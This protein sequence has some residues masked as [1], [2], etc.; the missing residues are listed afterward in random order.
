MLQYSM[1]RSV[2]R[3]F[4]SA[5]LLSVVFLLLQSLP[6]VLAQRAGDGGHIF[7][8][9]LLNPTDGYSYLAKMRQGFEGAWSFTLPY[10]AQ[11]GQ[12]AAI[13]LYYLLLGHVAR[14]L[15]WSLVFTFHGA[16]LLGAAA[17]C[18][19]LYR[20]FNAIVPGLRTWALAIALFGSGF[21]WL[22]VASGAFT[23][24]FWVAEMYPFLAS[25]ANAHFPLG[26]ALQIFLIT[27]TDPPRPLAWLLA[28][29]VGAV[30]YP[31]GWAV[32]AA[33]LCAAALLAA[34]RKQESAAQWKQA[35]WVVAGGLPYALYALV[36][37]NTHPALAGWNVQN[38][39]PAMPLWDLVTS[40][41]P[42]LLLALPSVYFALT[43]RQ[44]AV[45]L[46][47]IWLLVCLVFLYLPFGLQRRMSSG[48]YIPVIGLAVFAIQHWLHAAARRRL[49]LVLLFLLVLPTNLLILL[50]GMQASRE[51]EAALFLRADEVAAY[52][53]LT[54]HSAPGALL[55]APERNS[56]HAPA[57]VDVRVW[58]AHP[59]ETVQAEQ[60]KGEQ[61]AFFA[62]DLPRETFLAAHA[63]DYI[64]WDVSTA[65]DTTL[66]GWHEV[67]ADGSVLLWAR[68]VE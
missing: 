28:A 56:L 40:L 44:R 36:I 10:S 65:P 21:G 25:F 30:V 19:A 38:I 12:P 39:T 54:A 18:A 31:F 49:A 24:D 62:D 66:H 23:S 50:G 22:A 59:F 51:Q 68:D 33:V 34:L 16:R 58:Y 67:F 4:L 3:Q 26:L 47:A 14:V 1:R 63:V 42:A 29:A 20:F 9:F 37:V 57:F 41:A 15:G 27:P 32:A 46:L 7:G 2:R 48:L 35:T 64:L 60:R 45:Q 17:L 6:Y 43:Q 11:P 8:G 53:W 55:L 52:Q 13:N 61:Q 5:A